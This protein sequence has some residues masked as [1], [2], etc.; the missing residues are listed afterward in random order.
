[1]HPQPFFSN[2][3]NLTRNGSKPVAVFFEQK[4][5]PN[6]DILHSKVLPDKETRNIISKFD[7]VQLNIWSSKKITTP[8]GKTTTA[9]EWAKALDIQFAPSIVVFNNKGK[10]IIRSE[11]FFKIFH[12]QSIF[13]Y[14]LTEA[15]K[16]EASFQRYL[17][18]R[19]DHIRESGKSVDIWRYADEEVGKG[20]K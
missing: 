17:T 10:E 5:C 16:K 7:T 3:Y 6:C 19:A 4:D 12:T 2:N 15:Y 20:A 14:V 11:A 13:D 18:A 1:M 9:K 8:S